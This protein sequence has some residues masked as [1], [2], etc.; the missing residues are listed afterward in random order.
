MCL[1]RAWKRKALGWERCGRLVPQKQQSPYISV[2]A[3]SYMVRHQESKFLI[4]IYFLTF[5]Y[6]LRNY[7]TPIPNYIIAGVRYASSYGWFG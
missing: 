1:E 7:P 6:L 2:E 5:L 4:M 3:S